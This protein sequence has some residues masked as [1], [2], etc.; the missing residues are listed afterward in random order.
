MMVPDGG[1]SLISFDADLVWRKLRSL[2]TRRAWSG[3]IGIPHDPNATDPLVLCKTIEL[4]TRPSRTYGAHERGR[5]SAARGAGRACPAAKGR[6]VIRNS[7]NIAFTLAEM[8]H[9]RPRA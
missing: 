9:G 4:L 7:C 2:I 1:H 5:G 6:E 8:M 3:N